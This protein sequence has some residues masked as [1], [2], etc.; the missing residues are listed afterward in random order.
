MILRLLKNV[1]SQH[2]RNLLSNGLGA[3]PP[4]GYGIYHL[5]VYVNY[6]KFCN[7]FLQL[8]HHNTNNKSLFDSC[9]KT[10]MIQVE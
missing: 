9:I 7:H 4:M 10:F 5:S 1:E 8:S 3:T 2:G 6:F